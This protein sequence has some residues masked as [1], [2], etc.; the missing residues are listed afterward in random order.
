MWEAGKIR[1]IEGFKQTVMAR[2]LGPS[3]SKTAAQTT[4]EVT[5]GS[6]PL[7]VRTQNGSQPFTY[8]TA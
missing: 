7:C 8:G 5:A 4:K 6:D 1:K 3:I 2:W